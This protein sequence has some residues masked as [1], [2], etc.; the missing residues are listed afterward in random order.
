[1]LV[2]HC[3]C[4]SKQELLSKERHYITTIEYVNK[5]IPTR[6][7]AEWRQDNKDKIKAYSQDY[8]QRKYT[9]DIC[10]VTISMPKKAR[11]LR[12]AKHIQNAN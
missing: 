8:M 9:C 6:T 4:E 7:K 11:H 12:T 10:N 2:E 5:N 1:M 3:S